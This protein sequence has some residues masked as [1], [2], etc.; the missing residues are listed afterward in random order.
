MIHTRKILP[1][2]FHTLD[3]TGLNMVESSINVWK[4]GV[5]S[6]LAGITRFQTN[7]DVYISSIIINH[8]FPEKSRGNLLQSFVP[9]QMQT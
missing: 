7:H 8:I 1:A 6:S 3:S 2:W 4:F 9:P 5:I